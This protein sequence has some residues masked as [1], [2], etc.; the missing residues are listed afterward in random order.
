VLAYDADAA[1]QAA[2]ERYYEWERRFEVD[3]RVA[4]LPPGAD[5]ADL[6]QRDP[7][8]L[9]QA[10]ADAQ[11]YLGFRLDRLFGRADLSSP[12]G[13]VPAP[14]TPWR[15]WPSTPTSWFATST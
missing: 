10:V 12:E 9:A 5:P 1:G 14:P 8:A 15:W 11:P 4:A 13:R 2:A 7:A 6:A 3:I